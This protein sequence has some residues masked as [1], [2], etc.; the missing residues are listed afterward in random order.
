[1]GAPVVWPTRI[2]EYNDLVRAL[3]GADGG[4]ANKPVV[5]SLRAWI[6][7]PMSLCQYLLAI[8][9]V[10]NI[11]TTSIELGQKV[12][13]ILGLHDDIYTPA[14]DEPG[15]CCAYVELVF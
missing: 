14:L 9:S 12:Y 13:S 11:M 7:A 2:F 10:A 8:A 15:L 1:M 4:G 5:G 6:A 3:T